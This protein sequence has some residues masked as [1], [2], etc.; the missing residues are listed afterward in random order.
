MLMAITQCSLMCHTRTLIKSSQGSLPPLSL[1]MT[2]FDMCWCSSPVQLTLTLRWG[3]L[4][5]LRICRILTKV[6]RNDHKFSSAHTRGMRR[7][8]RS[9]RRLQKATKAHPST[10]WDIRESVRVSKSDEACVGIRGPEFNALHIN[11][12][13]M[14]LM[15]GH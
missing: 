4:K 15:S 13:L 10:L 1:W 3:R 2:L 6:S 5:W 12:F 9:S 14:S 7:R 8:S 11:H